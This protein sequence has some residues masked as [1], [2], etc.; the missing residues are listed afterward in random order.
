MS[1]MRLRLHG[2]AQEHLFVPG[3]HGYPGHETS[4]ERYVPARPKPPRRR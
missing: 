4:G 1:A 2:D 3:K